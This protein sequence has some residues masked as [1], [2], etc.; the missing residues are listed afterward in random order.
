MG[1]AA[2]RHHAGNQRHLDYHL[3]LFVGCNCV[4]VPPPGK[5]RDGPGF[6]GRA[7]FPRLVSTRFF[8][9][10]A[11]SKGSRHPG[12]NPRPVSPKYG[13]T[14]NDLPYSSNQDRFPSRSRL[15]SGPGNYLAA[16]PPIHSKVVVETEPQEG[17]RLLSSNIRNIA[18]IAHVDHGKTTLV[19]P[20]C[21]RAALSAPMS[22]CRRVMDSN[23]LER[24]RGITILAKNTAIFYH[25]IRSIS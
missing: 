23:D 5:R 24:E 2:P 18:I 1:T 12:K 11:V 16:E 9:G 17:N 20:C 25:D 3:Y 8:G 6:V 22:T 15:L 14:R 19:T 7:G 21:G 10:G 13:E 4:L